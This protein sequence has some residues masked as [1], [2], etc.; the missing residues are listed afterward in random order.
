MARTTPVH[1]GYSIANGIGT[2]LNGCCIHVW[3]EYK[4]GEPNDQTNTVPL[5][6][7]FYT[8]L[9]PDYTSSVSGTGL[10]SSLKVGTVQATGVKNGEYNFS[11]VSNVHLLGSYQGDLIYGEDGTGKVTVNGSF[12]TT[13]TYISGGT[14]QAVLILPSNTRGST[15]SATDTV[16]GHMS[17]IALSVPN[18]AYTHTIACSFGNLEG[19]INQQGEYV[20]E[21]TRLT[22]QNISFRIPELFYRQ[23]PASLSGVCTLTCYTYLGD[24]LVDKPSQATFTVT[25]NTLACK[26]YATVQLEDTLAET[27]ALTG[28]PKMLV[29]NH[30]LVRCLVETFPKYGAYITSV[31]LN[32]VRLTSND[33][34]IGAPGYGEM[35][36]EVTDSRGMVSRFSVEPEGWVEYIPVTNLA[37]VRR[38]APT[39]ETAIVT[40]YGSYWN[41]NFG[42]VDNSLMVHYCL[43][44]GT[45]HEV[46]PEFVFADGR[47]EGSFKLKDLPYT[48][49]YSLQVRVQDALHQSVKA[50]TIYRGVPVF[51]WGEQDFE[52]HVPVNAPSLSSPEI[53]EMMS[54]IKKLEDAINGSN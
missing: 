18:S 40:L 36:L 33:V 44:Q 39:S 5:T 11:S 19:Y 47:Y 49:S 46:Q 6:L 35:I 17:V 20:T 42:A 10:D 7:Y 26:P 30:S 38:E 8:A 9:D 31:K 12:T 29:R 1:T 34:I 22:G 4:F 45:W 52:F 15:L 53:T 21:Q 41:G 25:V 2:G 32:G 27:I 13:S 23:I 24:T 48:N 14:L 3:V 28:N 50:L 51:D 43:E 37:S 16:I 54:R